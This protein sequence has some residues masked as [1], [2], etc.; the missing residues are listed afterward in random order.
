MQQNSNIRRIDELGRIVIPKDIR[1]KLHIRDNEPLEVYIA[2]DE[3][4]IKKYS[5]L[6]DALEY[7]KYLVDI[8]FRIT[9]NNFIITDREHI[10]ASSD[11]LLQDIP[12]N[13]YLSDLVYTCTDTK[14]EHINMDINGFKIDGF[15]SIEPIIIDNDRSGLII[16]Y[17]SS[18]L[19]NTDVIKIFKNLIE[20]KLNNY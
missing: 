4:R 14:N 6:P 12:L 11:K 17:S 10:I 19:S 20:E 2:E 15:A 7:I 16:E 13:E 18:S 1:K 5:S 3:I 9:G 8:G